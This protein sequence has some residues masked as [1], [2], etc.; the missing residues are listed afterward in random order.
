MQY[1][2]ARA[3]LFMNPETFSLFAGL[4]LINEQL[5]HIHLFVLETLKTHYMW[6]RIRFFPFVGCI[7][8][9]RILFVFDMI[10]WNIY[11]RARARRDKRCM[12]VSYFIV[13]LP[14]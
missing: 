5:F 13:L 7:H 1:A 14:I 9:I 8:F 10:W 12:H 3:Y 6:N 4:L 2:R 11:T